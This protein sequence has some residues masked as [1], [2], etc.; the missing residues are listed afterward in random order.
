MA[1]QTCCIPQ[2][3]LDK[4][5]NTGSL[6]LRLYSFLQTRFYFMLVIKRCILV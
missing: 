1:T 5:S 4:E 3:G 2:S 6:I